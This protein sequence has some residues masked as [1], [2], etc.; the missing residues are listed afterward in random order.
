MKRLQSR[1]AFVLTGTPIENRIDELRSLVDFLDP[2]LLG[3]LF[4][5]N[6]E[7]YQFDERGRPEGYKNLDRLRARVRPLLLRR[8]KADVETELPDRTD[9]NHFVS[10]TPT[11]RSEY[12]EWER[13]VS[14]LINLSKRRTLTPKQQDMLMEGGGG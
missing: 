4:R 3:P 13:Q 9:L 1:Y 5:F 10:L 2:G 12:R 6:R 11:M 8:R 14:E 7:Y